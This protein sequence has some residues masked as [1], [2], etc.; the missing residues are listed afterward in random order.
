MEAC[1]FCLGWGWGG[2]L[3]PPLAP[4]WIR[5]CCGIVHYNDKPD[6]TNIMHTLIKIL[7]YLLASFPGLVQ[8]I[9]WVCSLVDTRPSLP[10]PCNQSKGLG[11]R[12]KCT[13]IQYTVT[14]NIRVSCIQ[15]FTLPRAHT[16]LIDTKL[17]CINLDVRV[18]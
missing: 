14:I 2:G 5:P 7:Q 9:N 10:L 12:L 17:D 18:C 3:Q 15:S 16:S 6:H 11:T 8:L 1:M 13:Y 4:C